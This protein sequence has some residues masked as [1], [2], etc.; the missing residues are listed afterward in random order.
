MKIRGLTY[1][2]GIN[3][4]DY[5]VQKHEVVSNINGLKKRKQIWACPFYL[6]WYNMLKRGYSEDYKNSRPTYQDVFVNEEWH[7][8][9]NFKRWM[10]Q[11]KWQ[12]KE[13]NKLQLDKDI[14][15]ENNYEYS[16]EN[17]VFVPGYINNFLLDRGND[18][19][20]WPI[21]VYWNK[22]HNKFVAQ[23]FTL[24]KSKRT[25]IGYFNDPQEAHLAWKECKH[26]QALQYANELEFEG[27]DQRLIQALRTRYL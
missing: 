13:G 4:A 11:Q 6:T 24:S 1:S 20:E 15:V 19:G 22:K 27:Y 21:G 12:D 17:C 18:R 3:D 10:E 8:F 9:S 14:L 25:I 16:K 23:C 5:V 26:Y 2:V 7:R